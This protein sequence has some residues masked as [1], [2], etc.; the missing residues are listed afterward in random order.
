MATVAAGATG[1]SAQNVTIPLTQE[2]PEDD[3]PED[4]PPPE[5]EEPEVVVVEPLAAG[6]LAVIVTLSTDDGSYME[7][8]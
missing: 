7:R 2:D 4:D 5:D 8:A 6:T 1:V 3:D